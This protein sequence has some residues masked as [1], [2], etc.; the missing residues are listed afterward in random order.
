M[1]I[2]D[3]QLHSEEMHDIITDPPSWILK[4]GVTIF[5]GVLLIVVGLS[6]IIRYPDTITT[7]TVI[8]ADSSARA[9]AQ[10][11]GMLA[12]VLVYNGQQVKR[13]Q[14]IAFIESGI[15]AVEVLTLNDSLTQLKTIIKQMAA[16]PVQTRANAF[17][18]LKRKYYSLLGQSEMIAGQTN[19]KQT[20][21]RQIESMLLQ[22]NKWEKR[23]VICAPKAGKAVAA[24]FIDPGQMLKPGQTLF[25]IQ[26]PGSGGFYGSMAISQ[27]NISKIKKGQP[28]LIKLSGYPFE[29]F[30]LIRGTVDSISELPLNDSVFVSRIKLGPVN[31]SIRLKNGLSASSE[32]ITADI[33]LMQRIMDNLSKSFAGNN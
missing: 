11:P 14:P 28:V 23:Y 8:Y 31:K 22:L 25:Y 5:F 29:E 21:V 7:H 33:S 30:G 18:D 13:G 10:T 32:V 20:A 9:N 3:Q 16:W 6:F 17:A 2:N 15:D 24:G 12:K 26:S 1:D 4:W 27:Q 19:D